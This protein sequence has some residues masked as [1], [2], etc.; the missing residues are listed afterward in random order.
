MLK[1]LCLYKA[2][3]PT[4][5]YILCICRMQT[6]EITQTL[7]VLNLFKNK[8]SCLYII[9]QMKMFLE[10]AWHAYKEKHSKAKITKNTDKGALMKILPFSL[11]QLLYPYWVGKMIYKCII[12]D[13]N[14]GTLQVW[15]IMHNNTYILN[16][17][18]HFFQIFL[19]NY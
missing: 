19:H 6:A 12:H 4:F 17:K 14:V 13:F 9:K 15:V 7:V 1:K 2:P 3:R 18:K 16:Q 10:K 11:K 8:K 5:L